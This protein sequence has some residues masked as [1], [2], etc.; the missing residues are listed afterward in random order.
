MAFQDLFGYRAGEI[1][2]PHPKKL[3]WHYLSELKVD[4][5][6]KSHHISMFTPF[7]RV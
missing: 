7:K 4:T 1:F 2:V 3:A 5:K 6:G